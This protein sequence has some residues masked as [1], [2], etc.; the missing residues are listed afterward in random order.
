MGQDAAESGRRLQEVY[1]ISGLQTSAL[2]SISEGSHLAFTNLEVRESRFDSMVYAERSTIAFD[3]IQVYNNSAAVLFDLAFSEADFN[4]V[5]VGRNIGQLVLASSSELAVDDSLFTENQ[6]GVKLSRSELQI[7][8]SKY[9]GNLGFS[10]S[11]SALVIGDS[12]IHDTGGVLI[13]AAEKSAVRLEE[14]EVLGSLAAENVMQIRS[15]S[16]MYF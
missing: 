8:G 12:M 6:G 4:N 9:L 3:G 2:F 13:E 7:E 10:L 1:G 16:S 14:T 15:G 5:Q 11:S